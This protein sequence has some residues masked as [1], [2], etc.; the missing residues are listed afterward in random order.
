MILYF[1]TTPAGTILDELAAKTKD[2]AW[3]NLMEEASHMPYSSKQAFIER[4][5]TLYE[6]QVAEVSN[7]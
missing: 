3:A 4:G 5:Y 1:P 6:M 7:E 2:E